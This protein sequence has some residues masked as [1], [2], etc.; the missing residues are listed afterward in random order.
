MGTPSS[1]S[2]VLGSTDDSTAVDVV[3]GVLLAC[4]ERAKLPVVEQDGVPTMGGEFRDLAFRIAGAIRG[5]VDE[6][7]PRVLIA[8][9]RSA[10]AYAGM[11]GTLLT[12]GTFCPVDIEGPPERNATIASLFG[13]HAV[14][15]RGKPPAFL[16]AYPATVPRIDALRADSPPLSAPSSERSEVAYV[17]FTSGSTGQPKGVKLGRQ[18]FSYFLEVS[19]RYFEK[20]FGDRWGQYSNLGYDLAVMDV[21]M[22]L[23]Q[24]RMLVPLSG[25]LPATGIKKWGISIWQSV[26]AVL[27]MMSRAKQ[28]TPEMLA[29]LRVMSFCGE[30]LWPRQLDALFTAR[31]DIEVFNTYGAT[32]TTG[33]NTINRLNARNYRE[34][35]GMPSVALGDDVPGWSVQLHGDETDDNREVV[36]VS[37]WIALGYWQDEER[38]RQVFREVMGGD[39]APRRAYFTGDRGVLKDGRRYFKCR[40]DRQVKICGERIELDEVEHA[41]RDMGFPEAVTV[42]DG[43]AVQAFVE[44]PTEVN[45]EV[46]RSVLLKRLS[47]HALPK[48][49]EGMAELPR[50]ANGKVDRVELLKRVAL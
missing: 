2:R 5:V 43:T 17:A 23:T 20:D 50:N 18:A 8:A 44:T 1:H 11:L 27:D 46:V 31:P 28:L 32:E 22:A 41:L 13:P 35:C 19:S 21:F 33:F 15:C 39:G 29:S 10:G 38:T 34:S 37:D 6:P 12:G 26:P 4:A 3:D 24:K 47:V 16:D 14:L 7:C 25:M 42:F 36:V 48:H 45:Q 40:L 49:V 30:P 9:P